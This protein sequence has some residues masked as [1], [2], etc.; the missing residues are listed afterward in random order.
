MKKNFSKK[1][2]LANL[3]LAIFSIYSSFL[4]LDF[5]VNISKINY[6]NKEPDKIEGKRIIEE[7][8]PLRRK[9]IN[10]GMKPIIY[11]E[12][13]R[14]QFLKKGIYP[15]G[16]VPNIR[17][18]YCNEGYGLVQ[19]KSDQIGLRNPDDVW[20]RKNLSSSKIILIG[21]SFTYGACVDEKDSI[22]GKLREEFKN[23]NIINLAMGGNSP[24]EY[25]AS[26]NKLAKEILSFSKKNDFITMIVFSNDNIKNVE[27]LHEKIIESNS[28]VELNNS[29]DKPLSLTYDYLKSI[30]QIS[31]AVIP[32]SDSYLINYY[33]NKYT[34]NFYQNLKNTVLLKNLRS[35]L[36]LRFPSFKVLFNNVKGYMIGENY[37]ENS[38]I[39]KSIIELEN[40]CNNECKPLVLYIPTSTFWRYSSTEKIFKSNLKEYL[41]NKKISY[42]D[43]SE[44]IDPNN[45]KDYAPKGVHLSKKG[46][47]KVFLLVKNFIDEHDLENKFTLH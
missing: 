14:E 42:I 22:A 23:K 47:E 41:S 15:I 30:N 2:S 32:K 12:K 6:V 18:Y 19:F 37:F 26:I 9:A 7:D 20:T 16:S 31:K 46:Y 4:I 3:S 17:N 13:V 5:F 38:P 11:P 28:I 43:S 35:F 40:I 45:R 33:K 27:G 1:E 25:L 10:N 21:D 24:Y 44:V 36:S 39:A 34:K 29:S 8:I